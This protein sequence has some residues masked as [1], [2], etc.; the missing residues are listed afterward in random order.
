MKQLADFFLRDVDRRRDDV[1]RVLL[2]QLH[3]PFAEVGI[4]HL[5][6]ALFEMRVEAALLGE[7]RFAFDDARE[8]RAVARMLGDNG[9]VLGR[10]AGPMNLSAQTRG[11]GLELFEIFVEPRH[12]VELDLRSEIAER[13]PLRHA[14]GGAVA[15]RT[16][17]PHRRIMPANAIA[18]G[19]KRGGGSG[20]VVR[21]VHVGV[22]TLSSAKRGRRT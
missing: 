11:V 2:A 10:I 6:A 8:R 20:V 5:D 3:D 17:K 9:V 13:F 19:D 4:G 18:I 16:G 1:A 7:H 12:R 15:F 14:M 22:E 21:W